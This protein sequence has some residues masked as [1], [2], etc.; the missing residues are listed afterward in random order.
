MTITK[1]AHACLVLEKDGKRLLIDP[2]VFTFTDAF[3]PKDVGPVDG[4]LLTHNHADHFDPGI[5][6]QFTALGRTEI[7]AVPDIGSKLGAIGVAHTD[8]R[9]GD[10]LTIAGFSV[11]VAHA[12]HGEMPMPVPDNA[13]FLIDGLL[14]P[15]DSF[16]VPLTLMCE[17]LALP[18]AG[19]WA[20]L[21]DAIDLVD[22][23]KPRTVIP[24]HEAIF[25][26][27]MVD[28]M[29]ESMLRPIL[30]KRGVEF[31]PLKNG[32]SR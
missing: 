28:R 19:P 24:I 26:D 25:K 21:V 7:F 13:A 3:A 9:D 14:H 22:Q 1:Y 18:I 10:S 12:P 16:D 15:G 4:I 23:L 32:E 27:F 30:E 2:G 8:V 11:K 20:R 6:Q 17:T 31:C 5:L 29:Y